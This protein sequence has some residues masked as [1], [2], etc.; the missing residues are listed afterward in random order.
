MTPMRSVQEALSLSLTLSGREKIQEVMT[1]AEG[2]WTV[3][4]DKPK[5]R[6]GRDAGKG[7]SRSQRKA[8]CRVT[9]C[10][11]PEVKQEKY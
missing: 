8:A 7:A 6:T 9:P 4:G 11:V 5:G 2:M 1:E 10:M 3:R